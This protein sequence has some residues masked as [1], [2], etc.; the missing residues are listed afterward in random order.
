MPLEHRSNGCWPFKKIKKIILYKC[1]SK[2]SLSVT[3]A[4]LQV[5]P[6]TSS[7]MTSHS[8]RWTHCCPGSSKVL[9]V[10][11]V[12]VHLL[13]F[14]HLGYCWS[15]FRLFIALKL[16]WAYSEFWWFVLSFWKTLLCKSMQSSL[17]LRN[18]TRVCFVCPE[19]HLKD[20]KPFTAGTRWAAAVST[21]AVILV[22]WHLL[23]L[24]WMI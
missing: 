18:A 5:F 15:P 23:F 7:L 4:S 10:Q 21:S 2:S 13:Q 20:W 22:L 9:T 6:L 12:N 24:R 1:D 19:Q 17:F 8:L 16:S 3:C 14:V 11:V